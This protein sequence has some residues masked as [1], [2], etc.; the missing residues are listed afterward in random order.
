MCT[1]TLLSTAK[2]LDLI[3]E[4]DQF[5]LKILFTKQRSLA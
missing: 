1:F 3:K 2:V 4:S 5:K